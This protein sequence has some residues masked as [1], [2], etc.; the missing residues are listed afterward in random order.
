MV[1]GAHGCMPGLMFWAAL[2]WE[3]V[4]DIILTV[5]IEADFRHDLAALVFRSSPNG[6]VARLD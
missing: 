4:S 3:Y 6:D 2:A 5:W 1:H